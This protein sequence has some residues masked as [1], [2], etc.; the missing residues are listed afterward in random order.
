MKRK[1]IYALPL[2]GL[3]GAAASGLALAD[4]T[5]TNPSYNS[6]AASDP[7]PYNTTSPADRT[8]SDPAGTG[9]S[10]PSR[11]DSYSGSSSRSGA[12]MSD[13]AITA[14]V[15][16]ALLAERDLPST[17]IKVQTN[18]GIVQLSGF[19]GSQDEIDRAVSVARNVD[20]VKAVENNIQM[21][22]DS[23]DTMKDRS[24]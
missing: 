1:L 17:Q 8:T 4:D 19:L 3:L 18:D 6:G 23:G 2:A 7:P 12:A 22:S 13:A 16:S 11:T 24:R 10:N 14:K 9:M 5:Q 15:K 20:D 21:K